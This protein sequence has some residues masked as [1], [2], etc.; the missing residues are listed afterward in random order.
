MLD[1]KMRGIGGVGL[2]NYIKHLAGG[3]VPE[4]AD[5]VTRCPEQSR[6]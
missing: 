5:G 2:Y 1:M 4:P 3:A 6:P